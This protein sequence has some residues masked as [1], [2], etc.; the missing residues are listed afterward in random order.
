MGDALAEGWKCLRMS[1]GANVKHGIG[2]W[3]CAIGTHFGARKIN[4]VV[5]IC[6]ATVSVLLI[7]GG[8]RAQLVGAYDPRVDDGVSA[9]HTACEKYFDGVSMELAENARGASY[10]LYEPF[11]REQRLALRVLSTRVQAV[12]GNSITA[13]QLDNLAGQLETLEAMHRAHERARTGA[14]PMPGV[15]AQ[16][17]SIQ[18]LELA[19][20]SIRTSVRAIWTFELA[21][22]ER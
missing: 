21:K 7:L 9:L 2:W 22:L 1:E 20:D 12:P 5:L 4:H 16:L 18:A 6:V 8:C 15:P 19:R 11:F 3:R 14:A 17:L 13:K 10:E